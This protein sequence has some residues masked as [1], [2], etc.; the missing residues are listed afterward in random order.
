MTRP[1]INVL[2]GIAAIALAGAALSISPAS[3]NFGEVAVMGLKEQDFQIILSPGTPRGAT[4]RYSIM[5]PDAGDFS[6]RYGPT[7]DPFHPND[8]CPAGAQGVVCTTAV[9]F[10]PRSLGRKTATLT[11]SDGRGSTSATIQGTG[12]AALCKATVVWCNSHHYSGVFSW[13]DGSGA[14]NVDVVQGVA[15][16]NVSGDVSPLTSGSGLLAVEFDLDE[17]GTTFF[18]ISAACPTR[19]P[20]EPVRPVEFGKHDLSSYKQPL[21]MSIGQVNRGPPRLKGSDGEAS[22]DLCP[23]SQFQPAVRTGA[24]RG[25]GRCPP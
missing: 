17:D 21:A 7:Q 8:P 16:C 3:H 24:S 15:S 6:L 22:W 23:N 19:Y 9:E 4:L 2:P 25:Q 5:G 18:R 1:P 14:V 13:S 10:R 12:V 20:P 11:V